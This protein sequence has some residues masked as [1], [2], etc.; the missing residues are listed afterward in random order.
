M[1]KETMTNPSRVFEPPRLERC[2][3]T[4][5]G[6]MGGICGRQLG[7][8]PELEHRLLTEMESRL[9]A[10]LVREREVVTFYEKRIKELES[11]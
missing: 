6:F 3:A 9:W 2:T 10:A 1:T 7:H 4:V 5:G 8:D 11:K